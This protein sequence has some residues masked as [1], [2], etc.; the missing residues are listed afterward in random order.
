[1]DVNEIER[2]ILELYH[3]PDVHPQTNRFLTAAQTSTD[4]W[5][6]SWQL[7]N[8]SKSVEVQYYGASTLH[9][10]IMKYWH[11]L[12]TDED[13]T[14]LRSKLLETLV[15]MMATAGASRIV[16]T[17]LCVALASFVVHSA[18]DFWPSAIE[19][20]I[21]NLSPEQLGAQGISAPRVVCQLIELL[22]IIPEEYNTTFMQQHRKQLVR[23][24][25]VKS[26]DPVFAF[27]DRV[28]R[29]KDCPKENSHLFVEMKQSAIKC[30]ANWS[31][32]LGQLV[33]GD[34]HEP[35]LDLTLE[36]TY[37]DELV[38]YAVEA[39]T[40]LYT[41]PEM[42]K[43]PNTVI[44]LIT[45]LVCLEP[46]L[47]KAIN[48]RNVDTCQYLYNL[49]IQI[50]EVHSRLLLDIVVEKPEHRDHVLKLIS[51]VLRCSATP[52]SYPVDETCSEAAFNF[53]YS[54][55]DDIIGSATD[56]IP[57]YLTT[58]S[59]IYQALIEALIIKV[60]FPP[61]AIYE[62][63]WTADDKETHRCYR[64]DIGDTMMVSAAANVRRSISFA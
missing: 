38:T 57:I 34:A 50:G 7:V 45:K 23:C 51:F 26:A 11:E 54:L 56:R 4:A 60:Q 59:P 25:L 31:H 33:L 17:R 22:T 48:E 10:K 9:L 47:D 49:F 64:Q 42:H 62:A 5:T 2:L 53:W 20:L 55:Q 63:E 35:L 58:F 18:A 30:F 44:R 21:I 12:E 46:R 36:A 13:K 3:N 15:A 8:P 24:A 37:D 14:T 1:M 52:G 41:H 27:A 32:L 40:S 29:Q 6:F 61:D 43:Y 16:Q 39:V 28:L 19:D